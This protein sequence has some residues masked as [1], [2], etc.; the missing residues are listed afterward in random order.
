MHE[1]NY[2]LFKKKL[3]ECVLIINTFQHAKN[4]LNR[5]ISYKV[6]TK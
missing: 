5:T 1:N 3:K 6:I 4:Y 2:I